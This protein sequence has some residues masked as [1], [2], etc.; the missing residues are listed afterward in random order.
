MMIIA[1]VGPAVSLGCALV[2]ISV[3]CQDGET[4]A[5]IAIRTGLS[6]YAVHRAIKT[7]AAPPGV[8]QLMPATEDGREKPVKLTRRGEI[9]RDKFLADSRRKAIKVRAAAQRRNGV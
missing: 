7:L 2:L 6:K 5:E 4:Q 3:M 1:E 8:V 9:F